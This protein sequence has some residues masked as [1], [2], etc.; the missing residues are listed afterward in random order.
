[1]R[2]GVR[3]PLGSDARNGVR[4]AQAGAERTEAEAALQLEIERLQAEQALA[5][6]DL[7]AAEAAQAGAQERVRLSRDTQQ[8]IAR[9]YQLGERDLATRLRADSERFE[10]DLSSARA[11]AELG[12]AISRFNQSLGLLP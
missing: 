11:D 2:V 1:M 9:A 5:R 3:I 8:L 7:S 6:E 4:I 10:A 12:R